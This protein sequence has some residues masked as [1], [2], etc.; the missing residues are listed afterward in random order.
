MPELYIPSRLLK[1][2]STLVEENVFVFK[3]QKASGGVEFTLLA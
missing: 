1:R 3:T 2:F